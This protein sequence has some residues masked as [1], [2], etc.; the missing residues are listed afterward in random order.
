MANVAIITGVLAELV[1]EDRRIST[2]RQLAKL[3]STAPHD[4]LRA[5]AEGIVRV[6]ESLPLATTV[7]EVESIRESVTAYFDAAFTLM[8]NVLPGQRH[9]ASHIK[10]WHAASRA[11]NLEVDASCTPFVY[12]K[13]TP[14]PKD[15]LMCYF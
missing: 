12:V 14:S 7:D 11:F 8:E 13:T 5:I 15:A 3:V 9:A 6:W 10:R 4:S 1:L 2:Q